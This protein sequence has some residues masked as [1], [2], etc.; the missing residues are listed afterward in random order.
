MQTF[1]HPRPP[2][3]RTRMTPTTLRVALFSGNY[4]YVKDGAN[5]ALNRLVGY[6]LRQGVAVRVYSPTTDT[7][8]FPPTGDLVSVPS[9]PIPGRPEYRAALGLPEEIRE[10]IRAFAPHI[11]HVS[12]PDILG[13]RAVGFGR[14]L[15]LPVVASVHTFWESYLRYYRLGWAVPLSEWIL[16][17]FYGRCAEVLV[18]S[19]SMAQMIRSKKLAQHI[20]IWA[21]GV[22]RNVFRPGARSMEWRRAQGIGDEE[23]VL[24]FVGRLVLEKGLDVLAATSVLLTERGIKHRV[25]VVGDGPARAWIEERLPSAI[26]TGYQSGADLVRAYASMDIFF[27]PSS[28]ETFGNVTIEAMA[29]GL[30]VVAARATGSTELVKEGV[31]GLFTDPDNSGQAADAVQ[32]FIEDAAFRAAAGAAGLAI[33]ARFDWDAVNQVVLDRYRAVLAEAA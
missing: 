32:C 16:T 8:A 25:L 3:H 12:A 7:P 27:Q 10:D 26:Y 17:N 29:C 1:A 11:F 6:L 30:P 28:T 31:S 23:V 24:G 20:H 14:S 22:D 2:L 18:P 19:E 5:G 33:A 4:N 9:V 13:H 21:R 15:G